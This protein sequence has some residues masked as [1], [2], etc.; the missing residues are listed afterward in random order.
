MPE[1]YMENGIYLFQALWN[2][3]LPLTSSGNIDGKICEVAICTR[4]LHDQSLR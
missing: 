4:Q 2:Y 3:F 1:F